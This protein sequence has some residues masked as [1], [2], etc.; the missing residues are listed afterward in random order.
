MRVAGFR[1]VEGCIAN[2]VDA[3][4]GAHAGAIGD[5]PTLGGATPRTDDATARM[6]SSA[7][8]DVR[9][10]RARVSAVSVIPRWISHPRGGWGSC[11]EAGKLRMGLEGEVWP[12]RAGSRVC[13]VS[14]GFGVS[15]LKRR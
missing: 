7:F 15:T 11:C 2:A 10:Y 8:Q 6:F 9:A 4:L 14:G 3:S 1:A 13:I 12:A 5:V